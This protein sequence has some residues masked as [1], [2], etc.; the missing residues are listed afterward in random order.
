[1]SLQD[2]FLFFYTSHNYRQ[3]G[4]I[5]GF[6]VSEEVMRFEIQKIKDLLRCDFIYFVAF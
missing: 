2:Q 1:M 4:Y 6:S 3:R 5:L